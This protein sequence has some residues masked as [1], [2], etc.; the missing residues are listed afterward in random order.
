MK[1]EGVRFEGLNR[2]NLSIFFSFL[3]L[4][5]QVPLYRKLLPLEKDF[6]LIRLYVFILL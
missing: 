1:S 2:R 3:Y 6:P 4:G 5:L